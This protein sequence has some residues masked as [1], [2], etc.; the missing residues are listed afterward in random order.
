MENLVFF[1]FMFMSA[2]RI[3][4]HLCSRSYMRFVFMFMSSVRVHIHIS[5]VRDYWLGSCLLFVFIANVHVR[6]MVTVN[7]CCS[8]SCLLFISAV[9][10]CCSCS[11]S[12]FMSV[13]RLRFMS[14][15]RFHVHVCC[16]C[17]LHASLPHSSSLSPFSFHPIPFF[18]SSSHLLKK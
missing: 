11:C 17:F 18:I 2:V 12:Q 3:Q 14:A 6:V 8:C 15:V 10:V 9:Y 13:V 1:L 4:V 16:P 5:A 7:V